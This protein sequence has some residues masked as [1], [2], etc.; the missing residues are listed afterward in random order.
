MLRLWFAWRYLRMRKRNQY[1]SVTSLSSVLGLALGVA[2]LIVVLS[3]MNGFGD[4]LRHRILGSIPHVVV[5]GATRSEQ[6]AQLL[7]H[8]QVTAGAAYFETQGMLQH[9]GGVL[10]IALFGIDPAAE[11]EVSI[12]DEHM[13]SGSFDSLE[14]FDRVLILG[15][16]LA[17]RWGLLPGDAVSVLIPRSNGRGGVVPRIVAFQIAGLFEVG[18]EVDHTIAFFNHAEVERLNLAS[19][20]RLGYRLTLADPLSAPGFVAEVQPQLTALD[21]DLRMEDWTLRFGELFAAVGMEKVMM[22]LLLGLVVTIAGF[23][24]ISGMAMLVDD[25]QAD[26][27]ILRTLG[28][29]G[30]MVG[31]LFLAHGFIIAALAL[32]LGVG[33]GI[34]LAL[35]VDPVVQLLESI[36]GSRLLA[37]SYFDSVPPAIQTLDIVIVGAA[38]L[39]ISLGATVYPAWRASR[40]DP[41]ASLRAA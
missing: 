2:T 27:A 41:A 36:S 16:P 22:G 20:G 14:Q 40:S 30:P 29:S 13:V 31:Q 38:A 23:N 33:G 3:V 35:N 24:V 17:F 5:L 4:E 1:V 34:A 32:V 15:A 39:V 26:I 11:P 37:G 7:K 25:K 18:A 21:A 8:P 12:I 10:P 28:M 6:Q 9:G 19:A